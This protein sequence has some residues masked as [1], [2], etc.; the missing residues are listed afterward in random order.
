M[1]PY[2]RTTRPSFARLVLRQNCGRRFRVEP[3]QHGKHCSHHHVVESVASLPLWSVGC[4]ESLRS[5]DMRNKNNYPWK[6]PTN[7]EHAGGPPHLDV[8][9]SP[10]PRR[11]RSPCCPHRRNPEIL[12]A[13]SGELQYK[14][15]PT[16]RQ[17]RRTHTVNIRSTESIRRV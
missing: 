8:S 3:T 11:R 7:H 5:K 2:I 6:Y 1:V 10:T 12:T 13:R 17:R 15:T 4:K 9:L 14:A 16:Y